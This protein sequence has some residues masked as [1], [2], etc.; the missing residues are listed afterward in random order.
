L[1]NVGWLR[2]PRRPYRPSRA[3]P[4]KRGELPIWEIPVS[5]LVIPF[6]SKVLNAL[7][8]R[9]SKLLFRLLYAESRRTG[10]PIVYLTHPTEFIMTRTKNKKSRRR[11]FTPKVLSPNYIR[12]HGFLLRNLLLR[13][14]GATLFENSR[15]LFAYMASFSD[16]EFITAGEYAA[17]YLQEAV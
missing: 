16:V 6:I 12:T 1:I 2:A 7:G 17:R 11:L 8:L 5:A 15:Q 14:D 3:N 10:K 9:M 13:M 4:F